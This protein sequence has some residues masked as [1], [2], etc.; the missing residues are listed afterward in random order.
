[1]RARIIDALFAEMQRN[2]DIFFLTADMGINLVER[3]QEAFP[4]RFVNVGIAEQNLIGISAGLC[5]T[6]YR[7][8]VY[9]ISN[10][11][12]HRCFEQIRN[13]IALHGY[14]VVLLGTSA[15]FD[16][17]PLGATHHVL[18]DWGALRAIPGIDIYSPAT[19]G[20][21]SRIVEM[22]LA[23]GRPAYVRLPKGGWEQPAS[24]DDVVYLAARTEREVLIVSYGSSVQ[25][26]L[27]VQAAHDQVSVL[28]CNRLRPLPEEPLAEALAGHRHVLVV[29]DHFP[30][31]GLYGVLCQFVVEHGLS[32]TLESIAPPEAYPLKVGESP[33]YYERLY[34]LD[35]GS[36]AEAVARRTLEPAQAATS[37]GQ[38]S[39]GR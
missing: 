11:L 15:G 20:Y 27:A 4:S 21:A 22:T 14:P 30:S 3:F 13:D 33:A 24:T 17:A 34:R 1:M 35:A 10:F 29:E 19:V 26:C 23:R 28:V 2:E 5:N 8:F 37:A 16:N 7:P 38:T 18:D 12:I 9:T 36:I 32:C 39:H 25:K 6:G 31:S